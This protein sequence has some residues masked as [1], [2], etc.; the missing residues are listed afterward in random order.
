MTSPNGEARGSALVPSVLA[1]ENKPHAGV[2]ASARDSKGNYIPERALEIIPE[3]TPIFHLFLNGK[4][5]E[6]DD[7]LKAG[8]PRVETLYYALGAF[9]GV[10]LRIYSMT[11]HDRASNARIPQSIYVFRKRGTYLSPS[12]RKEPA[13][14]E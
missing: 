14:S 11:L 5:K 4:M 10:Q 13:F 8:D 3:V 12:S 7:A 6:A 2:S 1:S 9:L